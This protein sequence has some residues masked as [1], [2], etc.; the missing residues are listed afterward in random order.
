MH[1]KIFDLDKFEREQS[2]S[3]EGLMFC[4]SM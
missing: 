4:D 2:S 1:R 3:D